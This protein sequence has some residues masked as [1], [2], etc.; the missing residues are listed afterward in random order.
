MK[1]SQDNDIFSLVKN[2]VT[3]RKNILGLGTSESQFLI[4][5]I[6]HTYPEVGL[7]DICW[8][9]SGMCEAILKS[10]EIINLTAIVKQYRQDMTQ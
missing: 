6:N 9:D 8:L 3:P 2:Q 1:Q 5:Y 7:T 4:E 10:G